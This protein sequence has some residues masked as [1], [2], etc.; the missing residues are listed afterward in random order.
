MATEVKPS[1]RA[2]LLEATAALTYRDGVSIGVEA[3]C[4]AAEVSKRSL[5]QLFES[6]DEL[7]AASLE[8]GASAYVAT[9]LPP[10]DDGR[11]PR[12]HILHVFEQL[13]LQA[14][15]P[16][17]QGCRYLAAQIELK[18]PSHPASRAAHQ[19]KA[20]LTAFFRAEAE[21]GGTREPDLLARQLSLVFDG[22][23]A[24]A[25]IG[26]DDLAGLI[27]PT[28]AALLDTADMR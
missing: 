14:S 13:E 5:Y 21:Q 2:R 25:G 26:A 4:K 10:A 7:L 8:E 3:L 20:N 1:P 23:S 18:D 27:T 24:R 11:S 22:A 15:T 6:K 12:E 17:Y 9:L 16:E 19:V 28:V